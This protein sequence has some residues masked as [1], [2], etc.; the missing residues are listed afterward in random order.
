[1]QIEL[2][3]ASTEVGSVQNV[4]FKPKKLF[5]MSLFPLPPTEWVGNQTCRICGG[6]PDFL[7]EDMKPICRACIDKTIKGLN[8][9][10]STTE[11][12]IPITK[13]IIT[14]IRFE[15]STEGEKWYSLSGR[16]IIVDR[17]DIFLKEL[18]AS[19]LEKR[20]MIVEADY[21]KETKTMTVSL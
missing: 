14:H 18:R 3:V 20:P 4:L 8:K 2:R 1:M 5:R 10:E 7:Q 19:L 21:A 9:K 13:D 12:S 11:T 6:K 16:K 15:W 17:P